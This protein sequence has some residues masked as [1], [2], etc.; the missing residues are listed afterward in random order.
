MK[1]ASSSPP[2]WEIVGRVRRG[3][4]LPDATTYDTPVPSKVSPVVAALVLQIVATMMPSGLGELL[5]PNC[6]R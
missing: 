6:T 5:D 4:P 1:Q 2:R 3:D